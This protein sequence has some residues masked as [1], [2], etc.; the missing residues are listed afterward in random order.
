VE[1]LLVVNM[2]SE[3]SLLRYSSVLPSFSYF[4]TAVIMPRHR[5]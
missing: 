2:F 5:S 3:M 1:D 4:E